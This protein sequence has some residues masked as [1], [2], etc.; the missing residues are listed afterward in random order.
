METVCQNAKLHHKE[1]PK[2]FSQSLHIT[3]NSQHSA[4]FKLLLLIIIIIIII[5]T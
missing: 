4:F 1:C 3:A 5:L 2:L